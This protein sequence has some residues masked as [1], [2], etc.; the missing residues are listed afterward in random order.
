MKKIKLSIVEDIAP[1]LIP[2]VD[3]MFLLLLFFILG[4]DMGHR[5]LE[6]VKLPE[7][8]TAKDDKP[9]PGVVVDRVTI[10]V[11]HPAVKGA[12][13]PAVEKNRV[14]RDESH[15]RI[16]VGAEDFKDL[17]TDRKSTRLNS[18]H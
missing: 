9:K 15:W 14:C 6:D 4:T 5:Q 11:H 16:A 17:G 1:N 8:K 7:A 18:S 2:L 12:P 10:N 13:C 3:I